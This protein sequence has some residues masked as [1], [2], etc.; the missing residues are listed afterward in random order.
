MKNI[1]FFL[2]FCCIGHVSKALQ[3]FTSDNIEYAVIKDTDGFVNI[4]KE[5][6][7]TAAILGKVYKY[8]IFSCEPNGTNWWKVLQVDNHNKSNWLQG[9]IYKDRATL[10][11]RWDVIKSRNALLDSGIFKTDSLVVVIKRKNFNPQKHKLTY[12][13]N[14]PDELVKIDGKLYWGTDGAIPKKVISSV[15]IIKS[16][17]VIQLPQT[18]FDD[19][20]EPNFD[21]ISVCRGP[22][23]TF[24]VL[25]LNSD[26]AGGYYIIWI[27]KDNKYINRYIDDGEE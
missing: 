13:T 9:Y 20:Y 11:K 14:Y 19:L 6:N 24:Y 3:E 27:L 2:S 23:N 22:E 26:G 25:M 17:T 5:P 18:A 15:K 7:N 16:N 4:R 12:Q 10:L 21:S 8:N 1:I